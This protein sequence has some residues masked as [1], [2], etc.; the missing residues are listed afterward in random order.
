MYLTAADH[1]NDY[2]DALVAD[3]ADSQMSTLNRDIQ[4]L[5]LSHNNISRLNQS[6]FYDNK[7]R[8]LQKIYLNANQL[9][10]IEPRAFHKLTGLIELDLSANM[11][12][13]LFA[14]APNLSTSDSLGQAA[15]IGARLKQSFLYDLVKLRQLNLAANQLSRLEPFTF[16]R[17]GQLRQLFLSE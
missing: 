11:L 16:V 2:Y 10:E 14:S 4:Q 12:T 6:E 3:A 13:D 8:N 9:R 7:F 1:Q 5:E 15:D 17:L